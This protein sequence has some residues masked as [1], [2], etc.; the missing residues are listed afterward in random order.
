MAARVQGAIVAV[1]ISAACG[2]RKQPM[3]QAFCRRNHGIE[4]D[5]HAG[6][7][8]RQ[9]SLLSTTDIDGMRALGVALQHGD[10][11]ENVVVSGNVL[12]GIAVG[13]TLRIANGPVLRVTVI[14]KQCH[15]SACAIKRQTGTCIMPTRGV[16][17][18][19]TASGTLAPGQRITRRK[20]AKRNR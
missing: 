18:R 20:A 19:V 13:D 4:G 1:C 6:S 16:F 8:E 11:A 2:E 17:T 9:V 10:F 7:G 12:D 3:P 14:G 15:N 5:A